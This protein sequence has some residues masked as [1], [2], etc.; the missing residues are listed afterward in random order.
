MSEGYYGAIIED[1]E[2]VHKNNE[3]NSRSDNIPESFSNRPCF[4][5]PSVGKLKHTFNQFSAPGEYL[6]NFFSHIILN[7]IVKRL[8]YTLLKKIYQTGKTQ[9]LKK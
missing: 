6:C 8:T 9:M 4:K 3:N 1:N 7:I 5:N 2:S